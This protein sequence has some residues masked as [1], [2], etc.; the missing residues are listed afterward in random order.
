MERDSTPEINSQL[1]V[2]QSA[3]PK[4]CYVSIVPRQ[5]NQLFHLL[6]IFFQSFAAGR[7]QMVLGA[8][9]PS[10]KKFPAC[11]RAR[12]SCRRWS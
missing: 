4:F 7:R 1:F 10:L 2:L 9:N 3:G 12:S 5:A 6:Q 8:R 11:G